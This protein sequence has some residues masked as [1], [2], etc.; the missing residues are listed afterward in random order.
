MSRP[1]APLAAS[2]PVTSADLRQLWEDGHR[3]PAIRAALEGWARLLPQ[4]RDLDWLA[5]ALRSSGLGAE[6][7]AVQLE[8]TRKQGQLPA[9]E[10]LIRSIWHSGDPWWAR[11]LL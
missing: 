2:Q 9:W 4:S 6:A 8:C 5:R 10:G 11:D 3:G 7:L 1:G